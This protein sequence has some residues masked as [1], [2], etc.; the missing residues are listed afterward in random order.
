MYGGIWGSYWV[1]PHL[2]SLSTPIL[3]QCREST[4]GINNKDKYRTLCFIW[5]PWTLLVVSQSILTIHWMSVPFKKVASPFL[6]CTHFVSFHTLLWFRGET[7]WHGL[8]SPC[9]NPEREDEFEG[10]AVATAC[11]GAVAVLS[12]EI[13]LIPP[14]LCFIIIFV[15]PTFYSFYVV[16]LL[17]VCLFV[18]V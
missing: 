8:G 17:D 3:E 10:E 12:H 5:V 4:E 13:P 7:T 1:R 2:S 14:G 15:F 18:L 6:Y 9:C 16:L 11:A